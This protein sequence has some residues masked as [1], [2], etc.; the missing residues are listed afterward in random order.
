[1]ILDLLVSSIG[2]HK[3]AQ[4]DNSKGKDDKRNNSHHACPM[5]RDSRG[6]N[7][8]V[9]QTYTHKSQ[10][11]ESHHTACVFEM[12]LFMPV[13]E[14]HLELTPSDYDTAA[15]VASGLSNK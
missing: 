6:L 11:V 3:P 5:L 14:V 9:A 7:P 2:Q 15:L 12:V 10:M 13:A 4:E 8:N 1:L